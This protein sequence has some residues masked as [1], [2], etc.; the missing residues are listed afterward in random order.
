MIR[1]GAARDSGG[2]GGFTLLELLISVAILSV[3]MV[4]YMSLFKYAIASWQRAM[5]RST[6][7]QNVS[8]ATDRMASDLRC[9][10]P[11]FTQAGGSVK[12]IG[13]DQSARYPLTDSIADE[14]QAHV[15]TWKSDEGAAGSDP[16]VDVNR[17]GYWLRGSGRSN[18]MYALQGSSRT[19]YIEA[20]PAAF[21][22]QDE[23]ALHVSG[24]NIEYWDGSAWSNT[25]N[26]GTS[27]DLPNLIRVTVTALSTTETTTIVTVV[28]PRTRGGTYITK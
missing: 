18:V 16:W 14:L 25:W 9:I 12:Y 19:N 2:R 26:T 5:G 15:A 21:S 7:E 3:I 13:Y 10:L 20:L 8:F 24:F 4:G 17:V 28:K 23:V 27:L 22:N 1:P 6:G 11:P